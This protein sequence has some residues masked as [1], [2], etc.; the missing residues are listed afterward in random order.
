MKIHALQTGTVHVKK[1]FLRGSVAAGGTLPFLGRLFTDKE[2]VALPIYAWLIEH[3]E[4]LFLVDTGEWPAARRNFLTQSTFT[5]RPEEG[6]AAQLAHRGIVPRDVTM[7]VL[8]HLHGD[9]V[10]GLCDLLGAPVGLGDREYLF[11]RS[12]FGGTF[13]RLT[14]RLPRGFA[15]RRLAFQPD[16]VGPFPESHRLTTA[17]DLVLVPTPG[18]TGG[19]ASVIAIDDGISYFLAGDVTY[20]ERALLE[21]TLQGPS[22]VPHEHRTTLARVL[23][24]V[25]STPTV[26]LPAHDGQS[27]RRLA[28]KQVAFGRGQV[29]VAPQRR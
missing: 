20:D 4:G 13:T 3:P 25:Q 6:I 26:Y 19:H 21:Q 22:I 1:S 5:I 27:G 24:Y 29:P 7:V 12:H 10:D 15:P 8:T 18:H 23:T 11:Y 16:A 9:H 28:T 14:T 2:S 17:G